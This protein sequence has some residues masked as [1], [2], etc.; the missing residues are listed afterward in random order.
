LRVPVITALYAQL[1]SPTTLRPLGLEELLDWTADILDRVDRRVFFEHFADDQAVQY[2][3][4]PFLQKFDPVL[5]KSLG[6]WY[7]PREV[8]KYQVARVDWA[9]K[10]ELGIRDGLADEN[11]YILDPSCGTGAYLVEVLHLIQSSLAAIHGD[12]LVAAEVKHA[13]M[14]VFGFELL[15]APFV[16][17]HLQLGLLMQQLGAPLGESERPGI[18][19]TNALTGWEPPTGVKQHLPFPGLEEERDLAEDVKQNRAILVILGNPPYDSFAKIAKV[20]EERSLSHAYRRSQGTRQPEGQGL[21]DLYVRFFRMAE[22]RIVERTGRGVICYISNYSWLDGLSHPAMRE[23]YLEV[24]D[25]IHI[26]SLNGDRDRT[27]KVAPDGSPDPSVFST[28]YNPQG[29][30]EGT[31]IALLVRKQNHQP[32]SKV[33]YR[34]FWGRTKRADLLAASG[35]T[36]DSA[37]A[38]LRPHTEL[39]LPFMPVEVEKTYLNWPL[40]IELMPKSFPGVKT[41]RD[42]VLVDIDRERLVR[43]MEL[44]FDPSIS[45]EEMTSSVPGLMQGSTG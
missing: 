8:V 44:Y 1:S 30:K 27:G 24:F 12:A 7:T 21:N 38:S 33:L 41:S 17:A 23:R 28:Q 25:S 4:E 26:D 19:L 42:D 2:F 37:Y 43:R 40:L 20:E 15:P 34:D 9:L 29:I 18:Y 32:A 13:A 31:A 10:V 5:R 16:V 45:H 35:T 22:R 11:V 14:I 36:S 3:Y 39:G 6:V